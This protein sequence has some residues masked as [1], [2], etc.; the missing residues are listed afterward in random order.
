[1]NGIPLRLYYNLLL[2]GCRLETWSVSEL[3]LHF[4]HFIDI[5]QGRDQ[6]KY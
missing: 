3:S 5:G 2:L 1:M 4:F 6:N